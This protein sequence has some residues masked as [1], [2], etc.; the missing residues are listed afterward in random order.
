MNAISAPRNTRSSVKYESPDPPVRPTRGFPTE[1]EAEQTAV[2]DF[3]R[4]WRRER[5]ERMAELTRV[6][7]AVHPKWAVTE[8]TMAFWQRVVPGATDSRCG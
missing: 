4:S 7:Q 8:Q 2:E 1:E 3:R 5:Y 6:R